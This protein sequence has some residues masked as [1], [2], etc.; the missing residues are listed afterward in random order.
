VRVIQQQGRL[1]ADAVA[2]ALPYQLGGAKGAAAGWGRALGCVVSGDLV[3][4]RSRLG[5]SLA[6][7]SKEAG[8]SPVGVV[9]YAEVRLRV[10]AARVGA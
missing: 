4:C 1:I 7:R 2:S 3:A 8:L 10:R 6:T 5:N 9:A